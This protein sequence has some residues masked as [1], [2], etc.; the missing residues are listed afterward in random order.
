METTDNKASAQDAMFKEHKVNANKTA[1]GNA[2]GFRDLFVDGLQDIYYA[3][4]ALIKAIPKMIE[5]ATAD[6]L[7]S[8]LTEHLE[9]TKTQITRLESVFTAI[10]EKAEAK[11][12]EAII[13]LIKEAEQMMAENPKGMIRD[14]A[15]ISA[16]QK[17]EH[18]EIA[19][20]GTLCAFAKTIGENEAATLL[21]ET[22]EEEKEADV[23]LSEIA[24][25]F[26]NTEAAATTENN[27]ADSMASLRSKQ[28]H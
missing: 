17:I 1:Q 26:I 5:N 8:A 3:E 7:V 15:I 18:Y 19:T 14:A 16:G 4:K 6:E 24:E 25:S 13:G 28:K 10:N 11:K 9:V 22:L 20:Y 23:K 21:Q 12:C 27:K 2:Q